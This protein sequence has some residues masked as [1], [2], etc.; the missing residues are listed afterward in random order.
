MSDPKASSSSAKA[1]NCSWRSRT[2]CRE[3]SRSW[4]WCSNRADS[5][6]SEHSGLLG[7]LEQPDLVAQVLTVGHHQVP[8]ITRDVE[9]EIGAVEAQRVECSSLT[10]IEA[11]HRDL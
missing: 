8:A 1:T 6:Q 10:A 2:R 3:P 5:P 11:R 4:R 7:R 9:G